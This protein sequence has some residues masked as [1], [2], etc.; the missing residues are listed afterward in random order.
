MNTYGVVLRAG[1]AAL[2]VTDMVMPR[3]GGRE[4]T[5]HVRQEYPE[6]R[7]LVTSAPRRGARMP[8]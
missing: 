8:R 4:L 5:S 1:P 2:V 3:M 6:T 7:L